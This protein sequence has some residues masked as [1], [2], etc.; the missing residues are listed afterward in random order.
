MFRRFVHD[1]CGFILSAELMLVL[2]LVGTPVA[3]GFAVIRDGLVNE[4]ND[5][6]HALGAVDQ[7]FTIVGIQKSKAA[8]CP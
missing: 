7:T 5:L 6:A 2:S 4:V 8:K 3:V 1:E